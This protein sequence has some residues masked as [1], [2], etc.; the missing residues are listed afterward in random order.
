MTTKKPTVKQT[1]SKKEVVKK[2]VAKKAAPKKVT[3][4]EPEIK[5]E[6]TEIKYQEIKSG[7]KSTLNVKKGKTVLTKKGTV[8]EIKEIV[9]KIVKYNKLKDKTT[10]AAM[11]VRLK[12]ESEITT[13]VEK[14]KVEKEKSKLDVKTTKKVVKNEIKRQ[15]AAGVEQNTEENKLKETIAKTTSN[16]VTQVAEVAELAK[17]LRIR[18]Y[19]RPTTGKTWDGERY[20]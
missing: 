20:V 19:K 3:V 17:H 7:K 14:E 1:P 12:L 13:V 16:D 8:E 4:K 6:T 18:G 15:K 9:D 5:A 11:K 10:I 2:P